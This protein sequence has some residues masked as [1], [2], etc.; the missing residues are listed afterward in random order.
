MLSFQPASRD[1]R[2]LLQNLAQFYCYDFSE[3]LE[4][5]V[6]ED[7]REERHLEL[8]EDEP[9]LLDRARAAGS[10]VAVLVRSAVGKL[11]V[12]RYGREDGA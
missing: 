6:G 12:A 7:T 11:Q 3:R 5:H 4:M 1:E 10:R 9:Q 8:D 2:P